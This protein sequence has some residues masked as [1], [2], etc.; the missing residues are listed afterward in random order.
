MHDH[1]AW[2]LCLKQAMVISYSWRDLSRSACTP[3][4]GSSKPAKHCGIGP[5]SK[6]K[7]KT[8]PKQCKHWHFKSNQGQG[9]R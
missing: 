5:V 2:E 3:V 6:L 9:A 8:K 7:Y 4:M 1:K